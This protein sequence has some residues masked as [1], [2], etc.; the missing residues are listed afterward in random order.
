MTLLCPQSEAEAADLVRGAAAHGTALRITTG[1]SKAQMLRPPRASATLRAAALQ[2]ITLYSPEE[3]V[4]S[5][6]AGTSLA[7]IRATLAARGQHLVAETPDYAGLFGGAG[8]IASAAS[9][10]L[11]GP[12]RVAQGAMRD[13]VLGLRAINGR[14]E[15]LRAGG[16]V[17]KNVTGLDLCKAVC[18]SFGTLAVITEVTLKVLP[19]PPASASLE[20]QD[21]A[22]DEAVAAMAAAMGSPF[23]VSAAAYL[24]QARCALLRLED[25]PASVAYR[26]EALGARLAGFGRIRT[27]AQEESVARWQE[28]AELAP[29][30]PRPQDSVWQVS[31][32]PSRGPA[33]LE[34]L[35]GADLRAMLDW[36]GGRVLL[37]GPAAM[38]RRVVQA[39]A[40]M[41]G[42]CLLLRHGAA[43][44]AGMDAA[45]ED[46]ITPPGPGEALLARQLKAAFDPQM[47]LNPHHL[48]RDF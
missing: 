35:D 33:V 27:L 25:D 8:S 30:A 28:I 9:G 42:R 31:V 13:H 17:L 41:Q 24:P 15:I 32:R 47:I 6:R 2:G 37:A 21:V 7:E 36:A 29:L 48:Y 18:G 34:A 38:H 20:L 1:G 4:L 44:D 40:A 14:G 11:S 10:N 22:A 46:M 39:A 3:L 45:G 5:A 23:G 16:R 12:R 26:S 43:G 19:R